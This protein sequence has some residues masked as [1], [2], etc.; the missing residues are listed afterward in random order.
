MKFPNLTTQIFIGMALGIGVGYFMPDIAANFQLLS[1]IF[2]KL[3]KMIIAPLVFATLVVGIAKLGDIKAV[4]RIG[5]KTL[6]Y[7]YLATIISLTLGLLLVNFF[8]PGKMMH[9]TL[10]ETGADIGI[11]IERPDFKSF[12]SRA[13]PTSVVDSM[14]K[15]E[16]LPLV[17]FSLFFGLAL[18][19]IGE[20]G[21]PILKALES[22]AEVMFKVTSYVMN[23]APLA[24]FGALAAIIG[25]QGL[26]VL[27]AYLYLISCFYG[28]LIFFALVILGTI[29]YFTKVPYFSLIKVMKEPV[30]LA[31]STATS[32]SAF[33]KTMV[34]LEKFGCP[35]KIVSFVLPM[36]YSFNLDA[37]MMYMT[38]ASIFIAQ[39]YGIQ[40]RLDQQFTMVLML[41]LASKGIAGV[42]R[43]SLVVVAGILGSFN[44]PVE[45]LLLLLGIDHI[46]D[47]GRSAVNLF[48][49][50]V[51]TCVIS[52]WEG[53]QIIDN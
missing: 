4:G 37:S 36:G 31:F 17:I 26:S 3:I 25:K 47:M 21:K 5:F 53:V 12:I 8:E 15:N 43:A 27:S 16:I 44:I 9:L 51:A 32:E 42:P 1:D 41:L 39:A 48:G 40:I 28:G 22:L 46:L 10:P 18:G 50:A 23:F 11:K 52:R 2:L 35:P 24:V 7:F 38:F 29:C 19:S 14:A 49:N 30:L 45:G 33:P 13:F 20:K 6:G 34:T